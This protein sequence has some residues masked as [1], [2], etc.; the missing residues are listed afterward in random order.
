MAYERLSQPMATRAVYLKRVATNLMLTGML[1][2]VSL[3]VGMGGYQQLGHMGLDDAFANASM[4]M[5]GMGPLSD[6]KTT[7]G[8]LFE[9]AY[10]L[11]SGLFLI[12]SASLILGPVV[13]RFLH[14]MHLADE[15]E[16]GDDESPAP[17]PRTAKRS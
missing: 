14:Q 17:K 10:A 9:G 1:T 4:I 5:S 15:D 13:H 11:Y 8:K 6:L 7:G 16:S 12:I 3:I 2:V